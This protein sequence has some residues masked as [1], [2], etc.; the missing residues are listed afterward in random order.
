MPSRFTTC[1][2]SATV[3]MP[4]ITST[5]A[6]NR[7][8]L[9]PVTTP[10]LNAPRSH[11]STA[12]MPDVSSEPMAMPSIGRFSSGRRNASATSARMPPNQTQTMGTM[13]R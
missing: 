11:S 13:A 1:D 6:T 10:K 2:D 12:V 7:L 5:S 3:S 9:S 4:T 8:K